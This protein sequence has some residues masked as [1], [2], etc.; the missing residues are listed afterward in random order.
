MTK[1]IDLS[2]PIGMVASILLFVYTIT[3]DLWSKLDV[4][5]SFLLGLALIILF[6]TGF[7][8]S[9]THKKEAK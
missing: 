3:I 1:Q 2:I 9:I 6:L 7:G 4:N 8:F 5:S